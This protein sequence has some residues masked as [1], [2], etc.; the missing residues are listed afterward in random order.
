MDTSTKE[1]R[2][3][4]LAEINGSKL[5]RLYQLYRKTGNRVYVWAAQKFFGVDCDYKEGYDD[6]EMPN[7]L[8]NN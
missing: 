6:G 7:K 8:Q 3:R 2:E 4:R 1:G 5:D